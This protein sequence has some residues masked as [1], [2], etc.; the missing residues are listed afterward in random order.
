[1][2]S[3]EFRAWAERH[4]V[5]QNRL[6][7]ALKVSPPTVWGWFH[8]IGLVRVKSQRKLS[9]ALASLEC[10]PTLLAG[11]RRPPWLRLPPALTPAQ[12]A[13]AETLRPL[14]SPREQ[15]ILDRRL[16]VRDASLAQVAAKHGLTRERIR[17]IQDKLFIRLSYPSTEASRPSTLQQRVSWERDGTTRPQR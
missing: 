15:D 7:R 12:L 8:G 4:D 14:L 16:V 5:Q 1:M 11:L 6:A 2:T 9:L 3:A 17:Q 13:N 10:R